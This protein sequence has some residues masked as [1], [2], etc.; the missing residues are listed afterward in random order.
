MKDY[1]HGEWYIYCDICGQQ[2]HSNDVSKLSTYTGRG[3]LIVCPNCTDD[4]DH[5]LIPYT[6]TA[7]Q[8]VPF[9][10]VNHTNTDNGSSVEDPEAST[11]IGT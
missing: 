8:N 9:T 7:E 2:W 1:K 4:I 5:G 6:I 3:G 11:E 10:R